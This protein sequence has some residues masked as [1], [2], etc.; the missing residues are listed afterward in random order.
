LSGTSTGGAAAAARDFLT[1]SGLASSGTGVQALV[2]PSLPWP[3]LE[4]SVFPAPARAR[5]AIQRLDGSSW[6]T[7]GHARLS[8]A[9]GYSVPVIRGGLYRVAWRGLDGPAITVR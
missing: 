1:H 7:V 5:V 8:R 9:G 4:G 3:L 2:A 6:H